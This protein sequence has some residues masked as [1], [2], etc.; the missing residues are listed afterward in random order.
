VARNIFSPVARAANMP[1]TA[2]HWFFSNP[3]TLCR[4]TAM[5]KASQSRSSARQPE[6]KFGP[7]PGGISVAVWLNNVQTEVGPRKM[8]SITISPRRYRDPQS[9]EWKDAT[10]YRPG[11]LPALLF[12]LQHAL[13]F[14][15]TEPISGQEDAHGEVPY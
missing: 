10:S 4:S 8:R 6:K 5:P 11:D 13:E 1:H 7:Y 15:F 3:K 14:V 12:G 2:K 9:G